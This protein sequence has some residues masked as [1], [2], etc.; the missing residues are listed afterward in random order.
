M[1]PE[2][3]HTS[4]SLATSGT[5]MREVMTPQPVTIELTDSIAEAHAMMR[6]LQC[7]HLPVTK[8]GRLVGIVS[9]RDLYL[10]ESLVGANSTIDVVSEAMTPHVYTTTTDAKLRDVARVMAA[11]RYG[12]A[13][14]MDG[15]HIVGIF[16]A[17]DAFRHL[18]SALR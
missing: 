18:V 6:T 17:T 13:I 12:S 5:S 14:I 1:N 15:E 4:E 8:E 3:F 11:E 7:R 16:T 2:P 9:Q 10:L